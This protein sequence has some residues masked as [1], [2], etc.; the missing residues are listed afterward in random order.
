MENKRRYAGVD[1]FRLAAVVMVIGIHI[2]DWNGMVDALMA[3]TL[4]RIA[5]PFFLVIAGY[6]VLGEWYAEGCEGQ[7]LGRY[8]VRI[9]A[10]Y[11]LASLIYLPLDLYGGIFAGG[12][13]TLG[14][15]LF[16]D[17]MFYH[18]WY[19]P[20]LLI[21][22]P[23][24]SI[25]V[26]KLGLPAAGIISLLLYLVGLL[27]DSW[28]GLSGMVPPVASMYDVLYQ[29]LYNSCNGFF[30][31]PV[32]LVLGLW[33]STWKKTF[34]AGQLGAALVLS[35]AAL[36][37]EGLYTWSYGLQYSNTMYL[38]LLPVL[39][40]LFLLLLKVPGEA[41]AVVVAMSRWMYILHPLAIIVIQIVAEAIGLL[42][43]NMIHYHLLVVLVSAALAGLTLL[44]LVWRKKQREAKEAAE[45]DGAA[46]VKEEK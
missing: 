5:A 23:L 46:P 21:A 30:Y 26:Q 4:F 28:Y 20:A 33:L 29:Y 44:C 34:M 15:M 17:G 38:A 22:Y 43:M 32:F 24:V 45:A 6:F 10:L 31:A 35:L 41:P 9:F 13:D 1:W 36:F 12:L 16:F 2:S 14:Q 7:I 27:G 40:C 25:L 37:V 18:L 19:F 42:R 11:I 8:W 39:A 3:G